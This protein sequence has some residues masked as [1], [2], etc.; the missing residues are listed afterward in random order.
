MLFTISNGTSFEKI[1]RMIFHSEQLLKVDTC[2]SRFIMHELPGAGVSRFL[3]LHE[4]EHFQQLR[5]GMPGQ[6]PGEGMFQ[7]LL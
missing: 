6:Y 4:S 5:S 7:Q 1:L 3:L 2:I